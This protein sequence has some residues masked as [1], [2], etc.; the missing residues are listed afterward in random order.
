MPR[1]SSALTLLFAAT[2]FTSASLLFWVQPMVAKMLLPLLGGTPAV[3]N[4][5]MLFFQAMLLAG[6]AYALLVSKYFSL[7]QQVGAQI[8]L[9]LLTAL[10]FPILI[11][12]A[13]ARSVPREGNPSL[14]L[15]GS[16]LWTVGLPFFTVSTFSPLLQKWFAETRQT[17]SRDPYFL[18][19]ASNAG[20]LLAL[21]SYPLLLEP[22]LALRGQSRL[23]SFVYA[24]LFVLLAACAYALLRR[25][26]K[27]SETEETSARTTHVSH[28]PR[29]TGANDARATTTGEAQAN[30]LSQ[31]T[32]D[33]Q[34]EHDAA[35]VGTLE[36]LTWRRRL[37]WVALAFVPSSL[38]LG[39]TTYFSTDIASLPLLWVVPLSL[40]LLTLVFAFARRQLFKPRTLARILPGV[41]LI[42]TLLYL[43]GATQPV[44]LLLVSHLFFFFVAALACHAQLAADRP[45]VRHLAE[46]YLLMSVG[47]VLGG[48]F[49]ALLAPALFNT[50]LEYPLVIVLTCLL[51]P[52]AAGRA[53]VVVR[54][55]GDAAD[56]ADV[57]HVAHVTH[58]TNANGDTPRERWLDLGVPACVALLTISLAL[59]VRRFAFDWV[60]G[61][62][63]VVGVPLIISYLFR[64]RPVRFALALGACMLGS[65]FHAALERTTL[66][67]ERNF[68]GTLR[69][70]QDNASDTHWLYHGT[71]IHGR[72]RLALAS[73]CEPLS[74]Y[75]REGPLGHVFKT[76][77]EQPANGQN[78]AIVGLGTGATTAYT[79]AGQSWTFYEINPAVV[80]IA[81]D[82]AYFTY[83]SYCANA[84]VQ[85]SLGDARLQLQ[86]APPA[87][88]GLIVL[89]A[90]SSDAIPMH[91]MTLEALDLY[92]SKLAPGGLLV[93]H[94]SNRSLDL[95]PVVADLARARNL[96]CLVYDDTARNQPSG[97]EPSQ[98]VV[99]SRRPEDVATLAADTARWQQLEG[100]PERPVWSD[101]FSNIISIFKWR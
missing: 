4:T 39:V 69:V 62:A 93:F 90:F 45:S 46:F 87:H 66:V 94:I 78:V 19:A 64:R 34:D 43:S 79:R 7:R 65:S 86:N 21:L 52:R 54:V 74:Y 82:P 53:G 11:S 12:E 5:C 76:F 25:Q 33:T 61:L 80:R 37:R 48:L 15:L 32:H 35:Q 42:F 17:A 28:D 70:T 44:W 96:S 55:G 10:T 101:D 18:Y 84:P 63:L 3:W 85:I 22:M 26:T 30:S 29:N 91:L 88:Y 16:L 67:A 2:L 60:Q 31:E 8:L 51:L 92:L 23:W 98:W 99:M 47:G 1:R 77:D 40:Y 81:R 68:F 49:N 95:H 97:K 9:L 41:A 58:V 89:D 38:M 72:Q 13:T 57:A 20:S 71:T 73:H 50:T 75:H 100:R 56:A 36:T 59:V 83:L 27:Q 6:Y 24:L 14:W